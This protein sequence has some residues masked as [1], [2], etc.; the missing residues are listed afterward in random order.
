[1]HN[2][3]KINIA[4]LQTDYAK[5]LN[6]LKNICKKL[7]DTDRGDI[8]NAITDIENRYKNSVVSFS[9]Y[10]G[11][12]T[13]WNM[14]IIDNQLQVFDFEYSKKT[15]P[16]FLDIYHFFMQTE[17]FIHHSSAEK[18][19]I[20]FKKLGKQL[21]ELDIEHDFHFKIY[22]LEIINLYLSRS[23]EEDVNE[24]KNYELRLKIL[25]LIKV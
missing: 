9:F 19:L 1:L 16:P 20:Q 24:K 7:D 5:M 15:Y 18:I 22:L 17:I 23:N 12:F 14:A 21:I 11:D 25:R 6:E 4:F 8:L 10:H 13:P 3:T 2:K